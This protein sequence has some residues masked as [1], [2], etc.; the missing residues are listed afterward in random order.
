[1]KPEFLERRLLL[2]GL[3][4]AALFILYIFQAPISHSIY[5]F[6][7]DAYYYFKV[8]YN[9]VNDKGISFDT[10]NPS[11]GFHPLWMLVILP[12]FKFFS[13]DIETPIRLILSLQALLTVFS[14]WL[15]WRYSST[16]FNR[17]YA[18]IASFLLLAF[19]SPILIA[20]NGL[21]S[22]LLLFWM[23]LMLHLDSKYNLLT[24]QTINNKLLVGLLFGILFL[25]RLDTAYIVIAVALFKIFQKPDDISLAKN[26]I[27][28]IFIY[29]P[30][31]IV[32]SFFALAYFAWNY[33]HFGHLSPISGTIKS[34]F[35]TPYID[36][37]FNAGAVPYIAAFLVIVLWVVF[38][39]LRNRKQIKDIAQQQPI[40][41]CFFTG[42]IIHF[43]WSMLFMRWAVF[44][45]HFTTY[46]PVIVLFALFIIRNI[47]QNR[48]KALMALSIL[49][50]F[51]V[52]SYTLVIYFDKG[53]H[54]EYVQNSA[55]WFKEHS[56]PN[57]AIAIADAGIFG[58]FSERP[59][60][61]L[62]GLI[63]S[64]EFQESIVNGS[65][66]DLLLSQNVKYIAHTYT[67]CDYSSKNIPILAYKGKLRYSPTGYVVTLYKEDEFF[68][69]EPITYRPLSENKTS[70]LV[71]WKLP[72][73]RF[74]PILK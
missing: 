9:I 23:L 45:W 44:Q 68:I 70:C 19:A 26:I 50:G 51:L 71:I 37:N 1:M 34:S 60:V 57:E 41:F 38:Q 65:I 39:L 66:K 43:L 24:D 73:N 14:F 29:I 63:N 42:T 49:T 27:R 7:D 20:L 72:Y 4:I 35:P 54:L 55:L 13:S 11:N 52:T 10:Y 30:S 8:A 6:S 48:N 15:L 46:I 67:N 5:F 18:V 40:L 21:E 58:Y 61:N 12:I 3:I 74:L 59:T 64:Y 17:Q 47:L 56:R 2:T 31:I 16:H 69:S 33:T 28:Q 25:I 22:A 62:D 32:F 53:Q 36:V